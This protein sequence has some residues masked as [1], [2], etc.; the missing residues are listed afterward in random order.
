VQAPEDPP[1]QVADLD[2]V[3]PS[4]T[5]RSSPGRSGNFE[6]GRWSSRRP[7]RCFIRGVRGPPGPSGGTHEFLVWLTRSGRRLAY[8]VGR[9]PPVHRIRHEHQ[10]RILTCAGR[11]IRSGRRL[12]LRLT[13]SWP[14]VP[15]IHHRDHPPPGPRAKLTRR[16]HPSDQEGHL[17]ARGT[18]PARRDSRAATLTGHRKMPTCP[19]TKPPNQDHETCRLDRHRPCLD[20]SSGTLASSSLPCVDRKKPQDTTEWAL[21][22]DRALG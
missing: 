1:P 19:S 16:S 11:M 12:Q 15:E 22:V 7:Q 21:T 8:P 10:P 17:R 13:A 20:R 5:S 6:A 4:G 9:R 18:P 2:V 3:T 14:W